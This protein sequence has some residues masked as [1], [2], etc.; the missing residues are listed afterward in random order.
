MFTTPQP[1]L[2]RLP[3]G[4]LVE[5]PNEGKFASDYRPF[6]TDDDSDDD[7]DHASDHES[8]HGGS[9]EDFSDEEFSDEE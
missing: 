9:D 4:A 3:D 1:F 8:N 6:N 5:W 2:V 7:S